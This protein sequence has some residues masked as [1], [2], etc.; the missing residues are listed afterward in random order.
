MGQLHRLVLEALPND[1][2]DEGRRRLHA[3][4]I[5]VFTLDLSLAGD[6]YRLVHTEDFQAA[7]DA[8]HDRLS[9]DR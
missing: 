6:S 8:L 1:L 5:P 2:P 4:L 7:V 3:A 9:A